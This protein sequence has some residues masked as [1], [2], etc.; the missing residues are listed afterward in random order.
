MSKEFKKYEIRHARRPKWHPLLSATVA[1]SRMNGGAEEKFY[2]YI[3]FA[4]AFVDAVA[5]K[6]PKGL[7][8]ED[9]GFVHV[10]LDGT[11]FEVFAVYFS[12]TSR[13]RLWGG[14]GIPTW[15]RLHKVKV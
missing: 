14:T 13:V 8:F 12:E 2:C 1:I 10:V 9:P 4:E 15:L 3:T 6:L 7:R 5:K 11:K